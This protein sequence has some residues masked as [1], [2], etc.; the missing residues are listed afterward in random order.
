[1][2]IFFDLIIL[3]ILEITRFGNVLSIELIRVLNEPFFA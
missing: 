2:L 3:K 1:M